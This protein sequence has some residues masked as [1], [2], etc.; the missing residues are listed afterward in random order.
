METKLE[1]AFHAKIEER[2]RDTCSSEAFLEKPSAKIVVGANAVIS[3]VMSSKSVLVTPGGLHYRPV[4]END[5]D[6]RL[7]TWVRSA[8]VQDFLNF[9]E[10]TSEQD[11]FTRQKQ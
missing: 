3:W 1:A 9:H 8:F 10:A 11:R 4:R 7:E 5:I 2:E 6:I